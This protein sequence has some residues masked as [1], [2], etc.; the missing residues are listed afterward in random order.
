MPIFS[1]VPCIWI[2][3]IL[4]SLE[5]EITQKVLSPKISDSNSWKLYK[6]IFGSSPQNELIQ[7][8]SQEMARM[9][10]TFTKI[11]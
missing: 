11:A 6:A 1:N 7:F 10:T 2:M 9:F 4:N 3:G 5:S 8:I